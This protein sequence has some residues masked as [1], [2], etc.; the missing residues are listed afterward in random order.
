MIE[1]IVGSIVF[2]SKYCPL[3]GH[4]DYY[5]VNPFIKRFSHIGII[6]IRDHSFFYMIINTDQQKHGWILVFHKRT[7]HGPKFFICSNIQR[8]WRETIGVDGEPTPS[9]EVVYFKGNIYWLH[10]KINSEEDAS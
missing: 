8:V 5:I 7:E 10:V 2:V 3:P 6:D 1:C 9:K 4:K